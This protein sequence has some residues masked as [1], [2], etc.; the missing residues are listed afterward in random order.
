MHDSADDRHSYYVLH[1]RS[2]T[3][4]HPGEP[5][6][7]ALHVQR[8]PDTHTF[9]FDRAMLPLAAMAQSWLIARG[10]PQDSIRLPGNIGTTPADETTRALEERQMTDG[11]HFAAL[12]GYTD[13]T[14][15]T[16]QIT[17]LL[18]AID[19]RSPKPF[20]VLLEELDTKDWTHTLSPEDIDYARGVLH[21]RRQVQTA[22]GKLYYALPKSR[23]SRV[24]DMPTSVAAALKRHIADG[25]G[26]G[27]TCRRSGSPC[28]SRR[29]STM[30]WR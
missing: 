29:A 26:P 12:A 6:I 30:P 11:D 13:D 7:M 8:D 15:K 1:D 22:D 23:M 18:R 10:C 21:V 24:A 16:P 28:C 4:G 3:G 9:S 17:V 19:E 25:A 20:R 27:L 14:S 5:Q 2:G